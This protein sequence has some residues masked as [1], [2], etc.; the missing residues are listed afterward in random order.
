LAFIILTAGVAFFL[1]F[2]VDWHWVIRPGSL[3][4]LRGE[5][6]YEVVPNFGFPPWALL[7]FIPLSLLPDHVGRAVFFSLSLAAFAYSIW[8]LGAG[9]LTMVG[10]L[11]SPPVIHSLLNA[12]FDWV[13]LLGFCM[14][15]VIGLFFISVK[16]QMGSVV[17]LFWLV[18]AWRAGGTRNV[19]LTFT[20]I[21]LVM[22]LTFLWFGFWP[23][24][25]IE[26]QEVSQGWNAS[27]WPGSIPVG[28]ALLV[29]SLRKREIRFAMVASPCLSP[30]V[31]LHAWSG[32]L[33]SLATLPYEMLAAVIGLW[34][35]VFIKAWS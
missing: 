11:L 13:P 32:A 25:F 1:P 4:I 5:S 24:H 14:P 29:A 31:L 16:P 19:L 10:F 12:N 3:A 15:P 33:A 21:G 30:Y 20:P 23:A 8:R 34:I 9:R 26:V 28:L 2:A 18:E 27:L 35:M 17:G 6:P 22:L 7:P